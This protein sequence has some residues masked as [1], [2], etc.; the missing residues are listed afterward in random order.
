MIALVY[1]QIF[2]RFVFLF[3]LS[4]STPSPESVVATFILACSYRRRMLLNNI[5][6]WPT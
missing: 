5:L 6:G 4:A 3:Y 1:S 2:L